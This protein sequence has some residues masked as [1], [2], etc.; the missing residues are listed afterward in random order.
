MTAHVC[1]VSAQAAPNLLP[2]LDPTIRPDEIVLLVSQKMQ[3]AAAA[4]A[5]VFREIGIRVS[6]EPLEDE[7]SYSAI[8]QT[9]LKIATEREGQELLLNLTG[10]T[11]LMALVAQSIAQ[12][13]N[14]RSFYVDVD[15][16]AI[17]WL[18]QKT[19][20]QK[21]GEQLRLKHYLQSYGFKLSSPPNRPQIDNK[22]REL[23]QTIIREIGS[24][25]VPITQL[26]W[27][28]QQA[29]D[30]RQL[31]SRLDAQQQDS[32]SLDTLL[33]NFENADLLRVERDKLI[34]S[35]ESAR[36]FVKGGWLEHY[37][38][39]CVTECTGNL[40]IRDSGLS[41][42]DFVVHVSLLDWVLV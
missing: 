14:W 17:T 1:L 26:N 39:D 27:L 4:L 8:E 36:S 34:F 19:P 15:T 33:R 40:G 11:K 9:M 35:S 13:A 6:Q 10:G 31:E 24:L 3:T 28:S 12:A 38:F 30:K 29:E 2:A 23:V 5:E 20:N 37:A 32:R 41:F 18:D 21:L 7:H 16:D 25:E 22:R 42:L